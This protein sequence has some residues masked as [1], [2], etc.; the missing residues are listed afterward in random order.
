MITH[1]RIRSTRSNSTTSY[2]PDAIKAS[3]RAQLSLASAGTDRTVSLEWLDT[4]PNASSTTLYDCGRGQVQVAC[5]R[6]LVAE[7][8]K[9]GGRID[10]AIR[11]SQVSE[12][13]VV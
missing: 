9:Q 10:D 4:L 6:T 7:T 12:L 11:W 3:L 1:A 2:P 13:G 5:A 8:F